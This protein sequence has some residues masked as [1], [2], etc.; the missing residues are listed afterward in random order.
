PVL[1]SRVST[2][3]STRWPTRSDA[4]TTGAFCGF[5]TE[6]RMV[7][8]GAEWTV[9]GSTVITGGTASGWW[10]ASS[11]LV[12]LVNSMNGARSGCRAIRSNVRAPR[13]TAHSTEPSSSGVFSEYGLRC[14][15]YGPESRM[16]TSEWSG[17]FD[18]AL[19]HGT[20]AAL[21]LWFIFTLSYRNGTVAT[22]IRKQSTT[23][24]TTRCLRQRRSRTVAMNNES[25]RNRGTKYTGP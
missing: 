12:S 3:C 6:T 13:S 20:C 10:R 25:G 14:R 19:R 2:R 4:T 11:R 17:S 22:A 1:G 15:R 5:L 7:S 18:I 9:I 23:T 24:R 21:M 16:T 8:A